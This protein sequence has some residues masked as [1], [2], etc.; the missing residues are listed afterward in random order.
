MADPRRHA[1]TMS[2]TSSTSDVAS[3]SVEL[4]ECAGRSQVYKSKHPQSGLLILPSSLARAASP[5]GPANF[6]YCHARSAADDLRSQRA[7]GDP[8][9]GRRRPVLPSA[10][11]GRFGE[12]SRLP[13]VSDRRVFDV[14]DHALPSGLVAP[15]KLSFAFSPNRL[16][17]VL[18]L[19]QKPT[20]L[21]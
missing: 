14:F 5:D 13:G 17:L 7:R 12:I 10:F 1:L 19:I 9:H 21:L 6:A 16:G 4:I 3:K 11:I 18:Q 20:H 15:P 8:A 2:K